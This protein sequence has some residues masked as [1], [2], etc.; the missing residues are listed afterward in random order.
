MTKATVLPSAENVGCVAVA[1]DSEAGNEPSSLATEIPVPSLYAISVPSPDQEGSL[2]PLMIAVRPVP[3]GL[4]VQMLVPQ[5]ER[6]LA[7]RA[8]ERAALRR[9]EQHERGRGHSERDQT[10]QNRRCTRRLYRFESVFARATDARGGT[11]PDVAVYDSR[12]CGARAER[13]LP[14]VPLAAREVEVSPELPA[15]PLPAASGAGRA[16]SRRTAGGGRRRAADGCALG[17]RA[18]SKRSIGYASS[19]SIGASWSI[20]STRP[21]GRATRASS[22]NDELRPPDVM[23]RPQ[24][25][26]EVERGILERQA[27]RVGLDEPRV[28]GSALARELEQLG[29]AIDAHDLPHERRQRECERARAAADVDRPLVAFGQDERLHLLGQRGR[30]RVLERGHALGGPR[31]TVLSHRRRRAARA[32]DRWRFRRRART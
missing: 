21:P 8:R 23:E 26:R 3:S 31:E 17:S 4:I 15:S 30:A 9:R 11:S 18:R 32:W 24:R 25:A 19:G 16:R 6:D 10:P 12:P 7:V 20:T 14:G 27:G 22:A 2:A 28:G 1:S 13:Q 29:N 5:R